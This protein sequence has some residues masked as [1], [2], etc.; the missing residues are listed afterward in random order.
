MNFDQEKLGL[1]FVKHRR[2]YF[3]ISGLLITL[4]LLFTMI[5]GLN[6]GVD[7]EG[8]TRVEILI[9]DVDV[10]TE[11]LEAFFLEEFDL[12][13]GETRVSGN[14]NEI[15]SMIFRGTLDQEQMSRIKQSLN[16]EYAIEQTDVNEATVSPVIAQELAKQAMWSVIIASIGVIIYV[17]IRFEYRF[18]L[19]AIIALLHD[20]FIVIALFSILRL[21][22][23]LTFIAAVLTIVGYSINDT[24]V[25][26]DRIRENL[27]FAKIKTVD[28]LYAVTNKSLVDTLARSINTSLTVVF[29]ALT[30]YLFGG[31]S[32]R[33]FSFALLV[34][35]LAGAYSSI[36]IAAQVW[37]TWKAREVR[38]RTFQPQK[39]N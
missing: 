22:V 17:S 30:L 15:V 2:K 20:A 37:V 5:F 38:A 18:A 27:K 24:I 28:D 6:L 29:A 4:G 36:F 9:E 19:C 25:I 12:E 33:N 39:E 35:L 14:A 26:F 10:T 34:G 8:G 1:D 13:P 31:E 23:D 3:L 21:E 16:A 7:F 11:E 32:I